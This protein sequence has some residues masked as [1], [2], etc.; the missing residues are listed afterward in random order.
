MVNGISKGIL[1][2]LQIRQIGAVF[3]RKNGRRE[4]KEETVLFFYDD[5]VSCKLNET[6]PHRPS[7]QVGPNAHWFFTAKSKGQK[8]GKTC[9]QESHATHSTTPN[10]YSQE[11]GEEEK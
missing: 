7:F 8:E 9:R 10:R 11:G 4:S 6:R 3:D 1:C 5:L 2:F